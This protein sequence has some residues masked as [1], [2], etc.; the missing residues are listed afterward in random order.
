M[1]N[2]EYK[3][4]IQA[5]I[6]DNMQKRKRERA[7]VQPQGRKLAL[8]TMGTNSQNEQKAI[9]ML[10]S[11]IASKDFEKLIN[12]VPY[13]GRVRIWEKQFKRS[14]TWVRSH[15][16]KSD[17]AYQANIKLVKALLNESL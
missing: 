13:E 11:G 8:K 4:L 14:K 16:I 15:T 3:R 9:E 10:K 7:E 12:S 17:S 5:N 2:E 6:L 1:Q